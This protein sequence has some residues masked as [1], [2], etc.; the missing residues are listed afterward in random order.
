[1][2]H[3][4]HMSNSQY[5]ATFHIAFEN[6]TFRVYI[7]C[8]V[9]CFESQVRCSTRLTYSGDGGNKQRDRQNCSHLPAY[10][11]AIV[12]ISQLN[13]KRRYIVVFF[14]QTCEINARRLYDYGIRTGSA[15]MSKR[16]YFLL[17]RRADRPLFAK[18]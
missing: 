4:I 7:W 2:C 11:S 5:T 6:F 13:L 18:L 17:W 3:R 14:F 8:R 16:S 15:F 1:M 12:C 9:S 10:I